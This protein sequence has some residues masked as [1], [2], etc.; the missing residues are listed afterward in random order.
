VE[1]LLVDATLVIAG[2]ILVVALWAAIGAVGETGNQLKSSKS[3]KKPLQCH[4]E[5]LRISLKSPGKSHSAVAAV[6]AAKFVRL[7]A[8][9]LWVAVASRD[10]RVTAVAAAVE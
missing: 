3:Y 4:L 7:S 10:V 6:T 5:S 9:L 8:P 1:Q 2:L